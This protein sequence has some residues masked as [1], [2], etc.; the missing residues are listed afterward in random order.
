MGDPAEL[1]EHD[2]DEALQLAHY[3]VESVRDDLVFPLSVSDQDA[4]GEILRMAQYLIELADSSETRVV[5]I[6]EK[7]DKEP[8][9]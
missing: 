1:S 3:V 5:T 2:R 7:F 4:Q 8:T 9:T 6:D